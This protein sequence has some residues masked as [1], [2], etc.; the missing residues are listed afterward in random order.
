MPDVVNG[1]PIAPPER[2]IHNISIDVFGKKELDV[3]FLGATNVEFEPCHFDPSVLVSVSMLTGPCLTY[4]Q[5]G[6]LAHLEGMN[7]GF[8]CNSLEMLLAWLETKVRGYIAY[9][10]Q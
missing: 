1:I 10:S 4:S 3:K 2:L 8:N 6:D 5:H 7:S 9:N